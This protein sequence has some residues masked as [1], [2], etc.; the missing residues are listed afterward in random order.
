V[1]AWLLV[2]HAAIA[3]KKLPDAKGDDVAFY[4]GKIASARFFT[5]EVL[6]SIALTA[7]H[8]QHSTLLTMRLSEAA[9]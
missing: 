3:V 9:F 6:P 8:V 4:E 2:R 7:Q 1:L 5:R